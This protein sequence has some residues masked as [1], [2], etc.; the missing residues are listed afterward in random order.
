VGTGWLVADGIVVTNRHVA[1]EFGRRNGARFTFAGF[2]GVAMAASID[3]RE[4]R[5]LDQAR[6]FRVVEIL[7]IEA[8]AGPDLALLRVEPGSGGSPLADPIPLAVGAAVAGRHVAVIGYPARDSRIPDDALMQSIFGDVYDQKRLAPG[9]LM[10]VLPDLVT[11]DCST[12][13]GNSGSVVLDLEDGGAVALHFAGRFLE[14]NHAVPAAIVASRVAA[15]RRPGG[16]FSTAPPPLSSSSSSLAGPTAPPAASV[17]DPE[18]GE[19][20][21]EGVPAD[22]V[23]RRGYDA[24]FLGVPVPLPTV[25]NAAD[26]LEFPWNGGVARVLHYQHFS[27]VMSRRR[28][29]CVVSAANIAGGRMRRMKRPGWRL[30]PRIPSGQQI[31]H[32]C[33]GNAPRFSRGHM[34]RRTDPVWGDPDDAT[35][36]NADS[37]HVTNTVPQVQPFNAGIWLGLEDY[38]L[39]HAVEDT[40]SISVFTGPFLL[41]DDPVRFGVQV[42]RSFWK[43]IAFMHD[44]SGDLTATGYV[45]SQASLLTEDEFVFGPHET[46][47][48]P[49][50]TIEARAGLTFEG[51]ARA[52]PLAGIEETV[53]PPL[54]DFRQIAFRRP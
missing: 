16:P 33:Y 54:R 8:E 50:A 46:Y 51:L 34:T 7:H 32:E 53:T 43:I 45:M 40:M 26:V 17:D 36:A 20:F 11:H 24:A 49:V 3:F 4:A 41:A 38:A 28:R 47:Q 1:R 22:Y 30:D 19:L 42:P 5:G 44:E 10:A 21:V 2:T 14:A 39:D 27:V 9:Q 12:L 15:I 6:E 18:D 37:M 29:M 35:R 52:D 13:G 31:R 48:V 25:V 23:G